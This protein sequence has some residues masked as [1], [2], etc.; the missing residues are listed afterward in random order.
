MRTLQLLGP[1]TGGIRVHV[2][3]LARQLEALGIDAPV[4][5]PAGV[6]DGLGPQAGV[7]PVPDGL[8][9]SS[10]IAARRALR[11]WR[12]PAQVVHAHGLK[13][14]WVALRG[15]PSRPLVVTVH[16]VVL[17][18]SAGRTVGAQQRLERAVLARADRVIAPTTA[19]AAG[20]DGVVR[21]DR[22][23]IV[24]PASPVPVLERTRTEV[25]AAIGVSD[26]TPL[27]TCVARL[28]P[29]KDLPTMFRAWARAVA[30]VPD[31][32]LAVVGEGPER[33]ALEALRRELG[34][35]GSLDVVGFDAHAVDW[36]GAADVFALSSVWEAI[37][38]VLA[39]A[40][41]LGVPVVTTDVGMATELLGDGRAG[42]VAAVGDDEALA[43]GLV[44]F[45]SD[46]AAAT[47]AGRAGR[48]IAA[49]RFDPA[50]LSA[51]VATVYEELAG[52]AR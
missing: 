21:R 20:L 7:V 8:S 10:L 1:S 47:A 11:P 36:I 50:E 16:N 40:M 4:V 17:E 37:P 14:A 35:E 23:R 22:V 6:L 51:A 34:I 41:Q 2:A 38:L 44:R 29:Q 45:L 31:A 48:E 26:D 24:V 12:G 25:R 5:G 15:R 19:I 32:R 43:D 13:A 46:P 28:H 42:Q 52:V 3:T 30:K 9:P 18:Q 33:A 39:E 49:R 27:V